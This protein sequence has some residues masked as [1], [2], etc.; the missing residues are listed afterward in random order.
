MRMRIVL[1]AAAPASAVHDRGTLRNA[2]PDA[3]RSPVRAS[4]MGWVLDGYP[5]S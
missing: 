4:S 5:A 1:G 2:A 3:G